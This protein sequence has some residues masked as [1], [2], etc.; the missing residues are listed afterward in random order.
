MNGDAVSGMIW[1]SG[2]VA[3][4]LWLMSPILF[5]AQLE[6]YT[7][8]LSSLAIN[9]GPQAIARVFPDLLGQGQYI[10][11]TRIGVIWLFHLLGE[12]TGNF[13]A[14]LFH[15]AMIVSFAVYLPACMIFLRGFV[16]VGW[17]VAL[18]AVMLIPGAID[19]AFFFNDNMISAAFALSGLA[20][21]S[22]S[23][24]V[25][26]YGG[27]GALLGYA[28]MCRTDA[29]FVAPMLAGVAWIAAESAAA[30]LKRAVASIA[31]VLLVFALV[32]AVSGVTVI[33]ALRIGPE[34]ILPDWLRQP[35][36]SVHLLGALLGLTGAVL[37]G[38]GAG[39]FYRQ[40]RTAARGL[41][42]ITVFVL[43]PLA[44][45]LFVAVPTSVEVRH[46]YPLLVP[47]AAVHIAT[48]LDWMLKNLTAPQRGMR[49]AAR[50]LVLF[51]LLC[52]IVPPWAVVWPLAEPSGYMIEDGPRVIAAG[53]LWTP[54]LWFRWQAAQRA[55]ASGAEALVAE[56]D[57]VHSATL[58]TTHYS[59]SAYLTLSLLERGYRAEP[60]AQVFPG[61]DR[62]AVLAFTRG[63]QRIALIRI[64]NQYLRMPLDLP[65]AAAFL[66]NLG[67]SCAP[68]TQAERVYLTM[69]GRPDRDWL[70][71]RPI[72]GVTAVVGPRLPDRAGLS[73]NVA[74]LPETLLANP[75]RPIPATAAIRPD[76]VVP[77]FHALRLS[78]EETATLALAA[79]A[80]AQDLAFDY[81][82][83]QRIYAP[84][85]PL[86]PF[87]PQAGR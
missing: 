29:V 58:V 39:L 4:C 56:L 51:C 54:L 76:W 37:L 25:S 6:G 20:W 59:D 13:G 16:P 78:P 87:S 10:Y 74:P 66:M 62:S 49:I 22:R 68:V 41:R 57:P 17:R 47:L 15:A 36:R 28:I 12:W 11:D 32:Y 67:L 85:R 55:S 21:A 19:T 52:Q 72:T 71:S 9:W 23:G 24:S 48:A 14:P 73:V 34:Y 18:V 50:G 43:Y 86:A 31:G 83:M 80:Q 69:I 61:C 82:A 3:V 81:D 79:K 70:S 63:A 45:T 75:F 8:H 26:A 33:D 7:A 27:A 46:L 65:Q 77:V 53:R 5:A 44:V 40:H 42:P 84:L 35:Y 30:M 38:L 64:E 1:K 2:V 60:A